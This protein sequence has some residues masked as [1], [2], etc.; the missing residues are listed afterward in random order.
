MLL[1][2][3]A[4]AASLQFD[5]PATIEARQ[6]LLTPQQGWQAVTRN[7]NGKPGELL[8]HR[9]DRLSLFDGN[10]DERVQLK[11]DNGDSDEIHYWSQLDGSLRPLYLV[12]RYQNSAITL[13]QALPAGIS[14]CRVNQRDSYTLLGLV[15]RK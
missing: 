8:T 5:C 7:D 3:L 11:P 14:Y 15:C 12:C 2:T 10:P 13:Q 9:L 1:T 4:L 6:Q